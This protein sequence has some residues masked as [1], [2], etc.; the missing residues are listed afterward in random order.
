ML[1]S[2]SITGGTLLDT[3]TYSCIFDPP[4]KCK[5]GTSTSGSLKPRSAKSRGKERMI[6]KLMLDEEAD[7]EWE[8]SEKIRQIPLWSN[9][10]SVSEFMCELSPNQVDDDLK[11][12]CQVIKHISINQ[13]RLLEM[14]YAGKPIY[15]HDIPA[16]F[17][18]VDFMIHV[19]EG[20]SLLLVNNIIHFDLHPGNILIS[21]NEVPRIIDFNLS[22]IS[23]VSISVSQLSYRYSRNF[24]LP[25]HPPD[26]TAVIGIDQSKTIDKIISN[27]SGKDIMK[28][29]RSVVNVQSAKINI[30]M[31]DMIVKNSF[32][33][34]GDI[35]GWFNHYWTKID[36]WAI[37]TYFVDT[38][39]NHAMNPRIGDAYRKHYIKIRKMLYCLCAID[40][41]ERWDC[42]Q[43]LFFLN[44]NSVVIKRYGQNWL[45][46]HG[47]PLP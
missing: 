43:A 3:G 45:D 37:G 16:N 10:F 14:P 30:D 19:L 24:H 46:K 33:A 44:P 1:V 28:S 21:E 42:M 18:L 31:K 39:K 34:G 36:S 7:V 20:A 23:N 32:I 22:M 29:I 4:L 12:K 40:P 5:S 2:R 15:T 38:I 11:K 8:I 47:R 6:S 35:I 26:Y 17:N 9:Y 25:Q 13:L 27:V 41:K